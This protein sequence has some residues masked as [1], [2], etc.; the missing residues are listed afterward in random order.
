MS[1]WS[2]AAVL[3]AVTVVISFCADHLVGSIDSIAKDAH[4]SKSFIG[5][6]LILIVGNAAEH[7]TACVMAVRNK[8]DL[9]TGVAIGSSI[10]TALLV[11]P[12]LV[13]L[14]WAVNVPMGL[15]FN[16]FVTATVQDGKSNYLEGAMDELCRLLL[17]KRPDN[18]NQT[19][20]RP[21]FIKDLAVVQILKP[22]HIQSITFLTEIH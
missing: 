2:A 9:A 11:T 8:M 13:V 10:Q 18:L 3:V 16:I 1:P 19:A 14:G 21:L 22:D 7:A 4:T 17:A 20:S 15:N 6:I 5:L 12:L